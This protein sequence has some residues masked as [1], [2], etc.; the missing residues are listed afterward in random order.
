MGAIGTR[1]QKQKSTRLSLKTER[2]AES[3]TRMRDLRLP[4]MGDARNGGTEVSPW[5]GVAPVVENNSTRFK[6]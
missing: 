3:C 2:G 4:L 5:V 6:F 1:T